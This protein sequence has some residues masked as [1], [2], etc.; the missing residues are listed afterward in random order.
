MLQHDMTMLVKR[1]VR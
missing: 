1:K